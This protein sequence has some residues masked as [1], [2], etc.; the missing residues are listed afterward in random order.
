MSSVTQAANEHKPKAGVSFGGQAFLHTELDKITPSP[1]NPR[2]LFEGIH[3][4]AASIKEEGQPEN[5]VVRLNDKKPG[6]YIIVAGERR[7]R[8]LKA[9]ADKTGACK[10]I[11]ANDSEALAATIVENLQREHITPLEE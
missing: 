4:L 2:K 7:F 8:A 6:P 10:I 1:L 5:L 9:N 11:E 3:E